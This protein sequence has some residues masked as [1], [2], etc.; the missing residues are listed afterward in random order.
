MTCY[1]CHDNSCATGVQRMTVRYYDRV[2]QTLALCWICHDQKDFEKVN[3]HVED[4]RLCTHC[5]ESMPIPGLSRGLMT[6]P[7]MVCLRCH[8]VK[9][10]PANADHLKAASEKIK[11]DESLPLGPGKEVT[12]VTCHDPHAQAARTDHRLRTQEASQICD[13]CHW[14]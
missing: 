11:P 7:K 8:Q 14:R 2:K 9:P 5:H 3:P 12:C 4:D 13:M 1:T 10:H 6:I